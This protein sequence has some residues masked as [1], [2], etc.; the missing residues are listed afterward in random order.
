[1]PKVGSVAGDRPGWTLVRN[2]ITKDPEGNDERLETLTAARRCAV[3]QLSLVRV[4]QNVDAPLSDALSEAA[5][6]ARRWVADWTELLGLS[7]ERR[8]KRI[9][10]GSADGRSLCRCRNSSRR[11]NRNAA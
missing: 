1:M 9:A 3:E 5:R 8:G 6:A 4:V 10:D 7:P 2:E 11:R